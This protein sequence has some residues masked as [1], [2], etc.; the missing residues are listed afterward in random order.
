MAASQPGWLLVHRGNTWNDDSGE[1]THDLHD[2]SVNLSD[3]I[4][5]NAASFVNDR[6]IAEPNKSAF[7]FPLYTDVFL[8]RNFALNDIRYRSEISNHF[9]NCSCIESSVHFVINSELMLFDI[10]DDI[11]LY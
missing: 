2:S 10:D 1:Q 5:R 6:E 3:S 7:F 11:I 8:F 4:W 9:L